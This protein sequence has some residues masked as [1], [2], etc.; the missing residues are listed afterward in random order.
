MKVVNPANGELIKEI[1][2]DSSSGV[3]AKFD[4]ADTAQIGWNGASFEDRVACIQRF[5]EL[6]GRDLAFPAER[7]NPCFTCLVALPGAFL[8]KKRKIIR[9]RNSSGNRALKD[10]SLDI[11]GLLRRFNDLIFDIIPDFIY[12]DHA[13]PRPSGFSISLSA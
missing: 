12:I 4:K 9:Q 10:G 5:R 11:A 7:C 8:L 2:E 13:V 1:Q 3:A 6:L